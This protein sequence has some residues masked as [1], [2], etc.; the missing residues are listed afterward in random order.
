[1][2]DHHLVQVHALFSNISFWLFPPLPL[3]LF[4]HP[5]FHFFLR[6]RKV[7]PIA[8]GAEARVRPLLVQ[9]S[10]DQHSNN[11]LDAVP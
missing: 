1:M 3:P 9:R 10:A 4:P 6:D 5:P 11:N 7:Q 8:A 2:M